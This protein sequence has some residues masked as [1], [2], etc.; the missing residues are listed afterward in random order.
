[1]HEHFGQQYA[2]VTKILGHGK[3]N[4]ICEDGITRL[5]SI[6][7]TLRKRKGSNMITIDD[8]I[9]ISVRPFNNNLADVLHRYNSAEQSQFRKG[10]VDITTLFKD[11]IL[12]VVD[13]N[14]TDVVFSQ[15]VLDN[16]EDSDDDNDIDL[17]ISNNNNYNTNI[18]DKNKWKD[19]LDDD[20]IIDNI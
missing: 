4:A 12:N 18:S 8:I 11:K 6:R 15:N 2:L 1:M 7:G 19:D 9:L 3:L 20:N 17:G 10:E 5:C 16:N 14:E 13:N